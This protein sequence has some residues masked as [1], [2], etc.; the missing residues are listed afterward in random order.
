MRKE[1]VPVRRAQKLSNAVK[2]VLLR[3]PPFQEIPASRRWFADNAMY[4]TPAAERIQRPLAPFRRPSAP[5]SPSSETMP[6]RRRRSEYRGPN[7]NP[8]NRRDDSNYSISTPLGPSPPTPST[9]PPGHSTPD[10]APQSSSLAP[11]IP[12]ISLS[13]QHF[14]TPH[15]AHQLSSSRRRSTRHVD[16]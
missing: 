12:R 10:Y 13:K 4:P 7:S 2:F 1:V 14:P 5:S 16:E 6:S 15:S 8:T 11:P 9:F 3:L